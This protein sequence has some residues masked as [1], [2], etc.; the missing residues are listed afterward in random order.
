MS[1]FNIKKSKKVEAINYV[2][3]YTKFFEFQEDD[4]EKYRSKF[5]E[6]KENNTVIQGNFEDE[7]WVLRGK[8]R[9]AYFDFDY[10]FNKKLNLAMKAFILVKIYDQKLDPRTLIMSLSGINYI[11]KNTNCLD[12]STVE[13]FA[14][15]LKAKKNNYI[16]NDVIGAGY[17]FLCFYDYKNS[18]QFRNIIKQYNYK[19]YTNREIPDLYSMILFNDVLND[20]VS[21]CIQEEK[22]KYFPVIIWWR[23]TS[24]I[25]MR[26]IELATLE[27]NSAKIVNGKYILSILNAKEKF[28]GNDT[29]EQTY[30]H[31]EIPKELF[32]L[33]HEFN[34]NN[35]QEGNEKYLFNYDIYANHYKIKRSFDK[36]LDI[37]ED[38]Y[39]GTA[40]F[41]GLLNKFYLEII[42]KRY[43][44]IAISSEEKSKG[45]KD[46]FYV[47]RITPGDTRHFAIC[48]LY[49]QGINPLTIARLAGHT[50]IYTQLSYS[51]HMNT[52]AKSKV[53]LLA[54]EIRRRRKMENEET[55]FM[56]T[57]NVYKK[58]LFFNIDSHKNV[59]P[60][61]NGYCIDADFPN[62]CVVGNCE[63]ECE[64]FRYALDKDKGIIEL[65]DKSKAYGKDIEKHIKILMK[66]I[67]KNSLNKNNINK[68]KCF[69][70]KEQEEIGRCSKMIQ[71]S[72]VNKA[73][74]D[75]YILDARE[76]ENIDEK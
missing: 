51:N 49:L 46:G 48:N 5:N 59:I 62:N 39:A 60:V 10:E 41:Y 47:E 75:S 14:E 58:S 53:K 24:C 29:L 3:S 44:Y 31:V 45:N 12:I 9:K 56:K 15:R 34:N 72:I 4:I 69:D 61:E 21:H 40:R 68:N 63:D 22:E 37:H 65:T 18:E 32:D 20:F 1:G 36:F 38:N 30:R 19:K 6:L 76:V 33:I 64:N 8:E 35:N 16:I 50:T 13:N 27:T 73:F 11:I 66:I 28:S 67:R 7:K 17:D 25:P 2:V 43:G 52:F 70:I 57:K 42:E 74:V 54:D 23:I 55:S 26:P 71:K